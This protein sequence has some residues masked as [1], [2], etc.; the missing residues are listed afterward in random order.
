MTQ[1]L[2]DANTGELKLL[3][4]P[5]GQ[6][7]G[8]T[9]TTWIYSLHMAN[10][11]GLPYRIFVSAFGLIVVMLSVTGAYIYFKKRQ[12]RRARRKRKPQLDTATAGP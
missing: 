11:F 9:F 7:G 6:Y 4:L 1:L 5:T 10:V 2:L 8:N 12:A 3:L